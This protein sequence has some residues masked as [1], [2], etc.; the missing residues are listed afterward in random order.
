MCDSDPVIGAERLSLSRSIWLAAQENDVVADLA[1]RMVTSL[2]PGSHLKI[3][4]CQ[5]AASVSLRFCTMATGTGTGV[6]GGARR[7]S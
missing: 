4:N 1:R 3:D 6:P 5:C 7:H 2:A